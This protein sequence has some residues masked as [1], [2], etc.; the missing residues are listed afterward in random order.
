VWE[1]LSKDFNLWLESRLDNQQSKIQVHVKAPLQQIPV[2]S[3]TFFHIH[4]DLLGP[5]PQSQGFS[6]LFK[7]VAILQ[8]TAE[9]S[10]E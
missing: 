9:I 1:F 4:E 3:K 2:P 7:I 8:T 10:W 5:L 6:Y